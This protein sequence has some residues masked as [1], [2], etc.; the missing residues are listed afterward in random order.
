MLSSPGSRAA[1][2]R[3]ELFARNRS[4][5][6]SNALAH[7]MSYGELAVVVYQQSECSQN[8]ETSSRPVTER[9]SESH[10]GANVSRK[11]HAQ[12]R[13]SAD[14]TW[15]EGWYEVLRSLDLRA[16]CKMLTWQELAG[17]LPRLLKNFLHAKYGIT[18]V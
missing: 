1:L 8:M 3:Q 5:A 2:L 14:R 9:F 16:R 11:L 6:T 4:Y 7:V 13:S 10:D 17:V 15:M 12:G 18:P